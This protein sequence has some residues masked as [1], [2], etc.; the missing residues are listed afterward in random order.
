MG[1]RERLESEIVGHALADVRAEMLDAN[2]AV[3]VRDLEADPRRH[4]GDVAGEVVP[5][6][7]WTSR[8]A[9]VLPF[10]SASATRPSAARRCV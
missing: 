3:T 10:S 1:S 4:V 9:A 2:G 8:F 7:P 6:A 5:I